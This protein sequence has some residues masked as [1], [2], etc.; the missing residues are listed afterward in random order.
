VLTSLTTFIHLKSLSLFN[1][2]PS[3]SHS[4]LPLLLPFLLSPFLFYVCILVHPSGRRPE[5]NLWFVTTDHLGLES[6]S[7]AWRLACKLGWLANEPHLYLG[8][9]CDGIICGSH[10]NIRLF[11]VI[12]GHQIQVLRHSKH[13]A[14]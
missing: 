10:I 7:L 14:E 12:S 5:V 3:P 8:F 1:S 6:V 11:Y 9:S 4:V 13:V 2:L